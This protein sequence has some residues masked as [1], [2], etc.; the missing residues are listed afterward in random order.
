MWHKGYLCL[1]VYNIIL[2]LRA[3]FFCEN[4]N[5]GTFAKISKSTIVDISLLRMRR[6]GLKTGARKV[7]IKLTMSL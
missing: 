7:Q 2:F 1:I 5:C 6:I 4:M 3:P